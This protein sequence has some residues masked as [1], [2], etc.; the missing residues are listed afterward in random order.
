[1]G[2]PRRRGKT[3]AT[4]RVRQVVAFFALAFAWSWL[5]WLAAFLAGE[6]P[7]RFFAGLIA[8]FGPTLAALA[9]TYRGEGGAAVRRL[10]RRG[11][12]LRAGPSWLLAILLFWPALAGLAFVLTRLLGG[13]TGPTPLATQPWMTLPTFLFMLL[14]SGPIQ[15]EFGWR[16][17]ALDRLQATRGALGASLL[18]GAVWALWHLPLHFLPGTTQA[19]LP[20][21]QF[22]LIT[23]V[24]SILYTWIHNHT[25]GSVLAAILF[26]TTANLSAWLFPYWHTDLGRYVGFGLALVAAVAIVLVEGPAWL[27]RPGVG[28][29]T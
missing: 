1:M 26:H 28:A 7:A 12:T 21:W 18:L 6:G 19:A 16:G 22:W 13:A 24:G 23:I 4:S 5:W 8:A 3:A 27:S 15:E 14:A 9:L 11:V 10:L 29:R 25:G 17:Y 20:I 2:T